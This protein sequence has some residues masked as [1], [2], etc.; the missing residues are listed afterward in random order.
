MNRHFLPAAGLLAASF[1]AGCSSAPKAIVSVTNPL[2][3]ERSGE[4]VEIPL[5]QL[6][7]VRPGM[8]ETYVV[9]DEAGIEVPSQVTHDSLLVF[10]VSVDGNATADYWIKA[11]TPAGVPVT[12][13]GRV[14]PERLDDLAWENDKAAYRAYGPAL[15]A[16]GEKAYGYDVFTKSVPEP[17]VEQRYALETDQKAWAQINAWQREGQKAKADSLRDAISYHTDHGNG[18]DCYSVGPTLGGG[19][20]ALMPDSALVYP[21]CYAKC[22]VLDNG[23]LRFTA[24]LTF[25]PLTVKGDTGVVET[26]LITLD[27]GSY[28]NRTEI[29]YTNLS[30]DTPLAVGIVIHPQHRDGFAFNAADGYIAYADSTD[31][32]SN[33]NGVMFLGAV[34][35]APFERAGVQWF[36]KDELPQRPGALGHVLGISTYRPGSTFVYYWGSGWSKGDMPDMPAWETCLK[37][38]ALRLHAPLQVSITTK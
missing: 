20:A 9:T 7:Q 27:K 5:S 32:A 36:G 29:S 16:T 31:N 19:T 17:V 18:M 30:A 24:R 4:M 8:N 25:H 3:S 21:Y 35:A 12:A 34:T 10:P 1:L 22:D 13:C 6:T 26:R 2:P 33:G 38:F 15:Q 28:L 37:D 11:G 14:Y 23:P